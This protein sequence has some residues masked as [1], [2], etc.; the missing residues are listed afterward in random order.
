MARRCCRLR[1]ILPSSIQYIG[2][3]I[4]EKELKSYFYPVDGPTEAAAFRVGQK[5]YVAYRVEKGGTF[6]L[7][8]ELRKLFRIIPEQEEEKPSVK[9]Q[10]TPNPEEIIE[11]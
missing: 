2:K 8:K 3:R 4:Q 1:L 6:S 5:Y 11:E 7:K 9:Q 10:K